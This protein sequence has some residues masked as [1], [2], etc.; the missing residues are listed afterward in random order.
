MPALVIGNAAL[1]LPDRVAQGGLV[2]EDG[3]IAEVFEGPAPAGALDWGGDRLSPGLVELH[4]D[5]LEHHLLP[6]PG[7]EW[8]HDQAI[9]AHDAVLAGCGITTVFDALRVGSIT[10]QAHYGAYAREV[11]SR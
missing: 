8:P 7:V 3:H 9:L 4:T 11:A 6:R 5:N 10:R 1:V 2:V